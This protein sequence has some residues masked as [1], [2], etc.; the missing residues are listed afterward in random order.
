MD[1]R[2]QVISKRQSQKVRSASFRQ[3]RWVLNILMI[4]MGCSI[5][6]WWLIPKIQSQLLEVGMEIPIYDTPVNQPA[7]LHI[8]ELPSAETDWVVRGTFIPLV[9]NGAEN[10][11]IE[12][13]QRTKGDGT[14][15]FGFG[16]ITIDT[17][18]DDCRFGIH[19]TVDG[20]AESR[21]WNQCTHL[22]GAEEVHANRIVVRRGEIAWSQSTRNYTKTGMEQLEEIFTNMFQNDFGLR[23]DL[24]Q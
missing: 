9:P 12:L 7:L 6:S 15:I 10:L 4:I 5:L 16:R 21:W 2:H 17:E 13:L 14:I 11:Q 24:D 20:Q 8:E 3:I 18:F 23:E 19:F 22:A 1:A